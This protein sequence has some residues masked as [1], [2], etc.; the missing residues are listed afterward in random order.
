VTAP[1]FIPFLG[2]A[3]FVP[4]FDSKQT[5]AFVGFGGPLLG[6]IG[7]IVL[8]GVW[9]ISGHP[10]LL[11]LL[12]YNFFFIN[13]FN[14]VPIRPLD[15][16]RITQIAGRFFAI[17]GGVI[18]IILP[19]ALKNPG[20]FIIWILVLMDVGINA[21]IKSMIGVACQIL[22]ISLMIGGYSEQ[23]LFLDIVDNVF[24]CLLNFIM[25]VIASSAGKKAIALAEAAKK[26]EE[27]VAIKE[28]AQMPQVSFRTKVLWVLA[29][30]GLILISIG[31]MIW[32][33]QFLPLAIKNR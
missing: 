10:L 8:F 17:I 24:A 28:E 3:I 33:E 9:A 7:S 27:P 12:S 16:G 23:G 2:A 14:L 25:F 18:V 11:L 22:M 21:R 6:I 1:V 30:V 15:G 4:K 20:L 26:S 29:Y 31:F 19:L 32:Q 13:L 5:E